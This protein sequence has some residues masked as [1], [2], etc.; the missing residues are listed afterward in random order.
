MGRF[1]RFDELSNYVDYNK[2]SLP[3]ILRGVDKITYK[4]NGLFVFMKNEQEY[5]LKCNRGHNFATGEFVFK[6]PL[7]RGQF[8][9]VANECSLQLE[10]GY[11]KQAFEIR[12]VVNL[13]VKSYIES[14]KAGDWLALNDVLGNVDDEVQNVSV[15]PIGTVV[16]LKKAMLIC[17]TNYLDTYLISDSGDSFELINTLITHPALLAAKVDKSCDRKCIEQE[18]DFRVEDL[19]EERIKWASDGAKGILSTNSRLYLP[20]D[21]DSSVTLD[22]A[23]RLPIPDNKLSLPLLCTGVIRL[24]TEGSYMS[25]RVGDKEF[26]GITEGELPNSETTTTGFVV[27]IE[28]DGTATLSDLTQLSVSKRL[29]VLNSASIQV[30]EKVY[31]VI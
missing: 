26:S 7:G 23:F 31:T 28:N 17:S 30:G 5:C 6:K 25:L 16:T 24:V 4:G 21:K 11:D 27:N 22:R 10:S 13:T 18:L 2:I 8:F 3:W 20:E 1:S 9:Q 12:D 19:T 29:K 15:T 14:L